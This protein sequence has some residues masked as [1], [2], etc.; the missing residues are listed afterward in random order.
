MSRSASAESDV[1]LLR[2]Q[3]IHQRNQNADLKEQLEE[4]ENLYM[5]MMS[6]R[7]KLKLKVE[8]VTE[9]INRLEDVVQSK[10][11]EALKEER[12]ELERLREENKHLKETLKVSSL[13]SLA[14]HGRRKRT[15]LGEGEG[16][17]RQDFLVQPA[18]EQ[19]RLELGGRGRDQAERKDQG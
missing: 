16:V 12:K 15:V 17:H 5:R 13:R 8:Q 11:D 3:L 2:K 10:V 6:E 1:L 9:N 14:D 7:D 4:R 19:H 18:D